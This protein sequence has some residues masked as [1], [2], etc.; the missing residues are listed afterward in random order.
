MYPMH[1][2]ATFALLQL[3]RDVA[4]NNRTIFTFFSCEPGVDADPGSYV[5]TVNRNRTVWLFIRADFGLLKLRE[6]LMGRLMCAIAVHGHHIQ[7]DAV[8]DH[9]VDGSHGGHGIFEDSFPFAEHEIGGDQHRFEFI[10]KCGQH[11]TFSH[12]WFSQRDDIDRVLE[13]G[14]WFES[15]DL[16]LQRGRESLQ[17]KGAEG[18]LHR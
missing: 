6:M 18:F 3:V 12:A 4:S 16:K 9:A 15:L 1:P 10:A 11:V 2:M 13:E 5:L 8:V 7:N 14:T 17:I